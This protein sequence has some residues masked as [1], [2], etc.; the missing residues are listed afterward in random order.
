[1]DELRGIWEGLTVACVASGPSLTTEDC[2]RARHLPTVAVNTSFRR[3]PWAQV[4]Y[5]Q[6]DAWWRVHLEEVI[7]TCTGLKYCHAR[8]L[9]PRGVP[10][11]NGQLWWKC[12]GNS[13]AGAINIASY[14]GAKTI[15]L[16]GYD[17]KFSAG[18]QRHWHADHPKGLTNSLSIERW[19][20]QFAK[21][22]TAA[23][24]AGVRVVNC[25]RE[26]ALNCFERG[27]LETVLR[28]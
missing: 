3:A 13:G 1:M 10:G 21:V 20:G 7:A 17:C 22:S 8:N 19:P 27:D 16:L 25:S 9:R 2:E 15:I 14:A 28:T 12:G 4:I 18:G 6:D 26:T 23:R 5:A 24:S 11:L